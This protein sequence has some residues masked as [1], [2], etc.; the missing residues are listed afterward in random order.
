MAKKEQAVGFWA[1]LSEPALYKRNQGRLTRQLTAV[2][3][4]LIVFLGV[5]TLSN[6]PLGGSGNVWIRVGI[7]VAIGAAG[8]WAIY[9]GVNYPR[10]ADFLI[11]VEAEMDKVTWATKEDLHRSTVVVIATMFF[12]GAVLFIYDL[13]W[14]WFFQWIGFLQIGPGG[15]PTG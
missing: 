11:S 12:L 14:S 10:F 7:P 3:A 5:W 2:G 15:G 9:R 6:G 1:N 4:A 8:A 13:V